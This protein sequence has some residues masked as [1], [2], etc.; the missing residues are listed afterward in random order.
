MSE[1]MK[2][3]D[4]HVHSTFSDGTLTTAEL[5]AMAATENL[6]AVALTDHNTINGLAEFMAAGAESRVIAVPGVEL[7]TGYGPQDREIHVLGLFLPESSWADVTK[8]VAQRN[9]RKA[10]SNRECVERIAR[11]GFRI[12]YDEIV[13]GRENVSINRVHIAEALLKKG[14]VDS[15]K[16]AFRTFLNPANGFYVEPAKL[17]ALEAIGKIREWGGVA[18]WAHPLLNLEGGDVSAFLREAVPAGLQGMETRYSLFDRNDEAFLDGLAAEF[19]VLP[20]GG[21]DFHGAN[22]PDIAMGSGRGSLRVPHDYYTAL[23]SAQGKR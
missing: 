5:I 15:I 19:G 12:F 1:K 2:P 7:S 10:Q 16:Q 23:K 3:C 14:Y 6:T 18:V 21:S 20:S 17:P 22:K 13:A 4:L 8:Y 9:E 11:A